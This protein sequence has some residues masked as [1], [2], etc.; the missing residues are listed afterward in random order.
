MKY[1]TSSFIYYRY[2][3]E[4]AIK[5]ISELGYNGIEVWGGRP[6]GYWEDMTSERI[7]SIRNAMDKYE[8]EISCFIPAQFRYPTNLGTCDELV[9]NNSVQY[10]KHSID[11]AISL[12]SPYLSLC[13]GFSLYGEDI[14]DAWKSMM[15]SFKTLVDYVSGKPITLLIEPAHAMETDLIL[16]TDHGLKAVNEI[17]NQQ[18]GLLL[19]TGHMH[20]NKECMSDSII[21]T[22]NNGCKFHFQI[23]DN[24]GVSDD[25]LVPNDGNIDFDLFYQTLTKNKYDG[26]LGVELGWGYTTDPDT[27]SKNALKNLKEIESKNK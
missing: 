25:H 13:P 10:L 11:T 9:R 7:L 26:Y 8:L 24:K 3:L 19:D 16:T 2:P 15:K 21:K 20:I 22:I 1:S 14:N 17:S 27:A 23:D 18:L 6:H 5:R 12:G 4:E